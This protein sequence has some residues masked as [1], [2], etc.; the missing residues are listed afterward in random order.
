M[1]FDISTMQPV[2]IP[3]WADDQMRK[4]FP[5]FYKGKPVR[6]NMSSD[7]KFRTLKV[8]SNSHDTDPREYFETRGN[9]RKARGIV[10]D[11]ESG[12]QFHIQ[13]TSASPRPGSGGLQFSYPH[14]N[15]TV[16]DGMIIQPGQRDLLFYLHYLCPVIKENRCPFRAADPW[17]EYHRPE[18]A[19]AAK[20]SEARERVDLEKLVYFDTPYEKVLKAIDGLA[21]KRTGSEER[22][23]VALRD[24]ISRGSDTF[25]K[26]AFSILG[27]P[28]KKEVQAPSTEESVGEMLNRL[29]NEKIIKNDEGKWYLR[30]KRG[31][32]DKWLTKP[33]Y[34]TQGQPGEAFFELSDHL[35]VNN[36]LLVKLRKQ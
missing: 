10:I 23:R 31:E 24:A 5:E 2:S 36:E 19:A 3:D 29:L 1:L 35:A 34:E 22:D 27:D 6:I 12:E 30:D 26:N 20:I 13:Y 28:G 7:K 11:P 18:I 33:F 25:K 15:V 4:D 16:S 17:Y 9:S 14:C 21:M 8:P 32:G